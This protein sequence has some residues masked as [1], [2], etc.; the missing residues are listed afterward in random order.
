M[1]ANPNDQQQRPRPNPEQP[2][3]EAPLFVNPIDG[4]LIAINPHLLPYA[5]TRGGASITPVD[6]GKVKGRAMSAMY[7]QTDM[8]LGQIREQIELLARQ[9]KAIQ[10]RVSIS[11]EIYQAEMNFE[12]FIG[13]TYHLY[14]RPSGRSV[15]SLVG[16]REWGASAP[17]T[18]VATVKLLADHTWDILE[19][20]EG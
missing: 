17:Y 19:K 9:A 4:D 1:S 20:A 16:P 12:P 18:F 3:P 14:R 10:D 6:R 7:E 5:H 2:Q 8:D 11:E 15:L 13:K